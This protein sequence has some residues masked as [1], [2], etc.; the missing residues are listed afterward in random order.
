MS[1]LIVLLIVI[2]FPD[3]L[4]D[5]AKLLGIATPVNMVFFVGFCFSL[6]II[7]GLTMAVSKMSQQI[8]DLSQKI[9]LMEKEREKK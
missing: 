8:K 9:A 7:F 6:I 5:G 4:T 3:L 2:V 1:L